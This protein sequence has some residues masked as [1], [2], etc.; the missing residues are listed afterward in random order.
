MDLFLTSKKIARHFVAGAAFS[1][2]RCGVFSRQQGFRRL[3]G[4]I[5]Y[6]HKNKYG[7]FEV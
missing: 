6:L 1:F 4:L 5:Q 3:S 7:N 2:N